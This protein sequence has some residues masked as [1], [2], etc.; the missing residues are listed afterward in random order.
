MLK[1]AW[2]DIKFTARLWM[3]NPGIA[4]T[5]ILILAVALGASAAVFSIVHAVLL[6]SLP[7]P[8]PDQIVALERITS[9]GTSEAFSPLTFQDLIASGTFQSGAA[10]TGEVMTLTGVGEPQKLNSTAASWNFFQVF[11]VQPA[12]GRFFLQSDGQ[13]DN[14]HSVVLG[15]SLW[16]RSFH[17]DPSIVGRIIQL[18]GESYLVTG[19]APPGFHYPDRTEIWRPLVF[20]PEDLE[21]RR[22]GGNWIQVIARVKPDLKL[23]T[24]Q[25]RIDVVADRL[26]REFPRTN[27]NVHVK[28]YTLHDYLVSDTR[29]PLLILLAAILLVVFIACANVT[30]LLLVHVQNRHEEISIR[31][32]LG[33]RPERLIQQ[34]LFESLF[35][36][37]LA[38]SIGLIIASGLIDALQLIPQ[39]G[40][41]YFDQIQI[42]I[43]VLLFLFA[44]I[45]IT[46]I[47]TGLFPALQSRSMVVSAGRVIPGGSQKL[48]NS[49]VIGQVAIALVLLTSAGLLIKSVSQLM[50]VDSGFRPESVYTFEIS[51]PGMKYSDAAKISDMYSH[52]LE[53]WKHQP[54][55]QYASAT[56]GLPMGDGPAAGTSF[57]RIG[58]PEDPDAAAGMRVITPEFFHTLKIP[59]LKGRYFDEK[60][61][62]HAP[63][64][65]IISEA[66]AHKYFPN[67][68]PLGQVLRVHV[69]LD[70]QPTRDWQI[71]GVVG[72]VHYRSLDTPVG[73]EIYVPFAQQTLGWM[74]VVVRSSSSLP[75]MNLAL[76]D[77]L[78]S[79]D[80]SL[81][82]PPVRTMEELIGETVGGRK[83]LMKLLSGF[84]G[85]ALLLAAVGIYGV[86]SYSVVQRTREIGLRMALGAQQ[87]SILTLIMKK[88]MVLVLIGAGI[89]IIGA[90][91]GN[92]ILK[93][94]L[95]EVSTTDPMTYL[96]GL[97]ILCF[98]GAFAIYL[99][100]R[101]AMSIEPL[102]AL[103]YE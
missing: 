13:L 35:L 40:I 14:H 98:G 70:G 7:Y 88:G 22:R 9:H 91:V 68:N 60:D 64:V 99:P 62:A 20:Q 53:S 75:Q 36:S 85:I 42:S 80:P 28:L 27:A 51:L 12:A 94:M 21:P 56:F 18:E 6:K 11:Q 38:G 47:F 103:R 37:F 102:E 101:R 61:D 43:P 16:Q 84:S 63:G 90:L 19:V 10:F 69:S 95:F 8:D 4:L 52:L 39:A 71:V 48:R 57:Q 34:F 96:A 5:S 77:I 81:A 74:E 65:M 31:A 58:H 76:R 100:A 30:N 15:Y 92:S 55:T 54:G 66:F 44:L 82:V 86:L 41:S 1:G 97:F 67:E 83:F 33:A 25:S 46:A 23:N 50:G 73:P 72:D 59:L 93:A 24:A 79:I 3:R 2:Q 78:H 49:L 87:S 29:R 89:G 32:A 17:R 26:A 45:V